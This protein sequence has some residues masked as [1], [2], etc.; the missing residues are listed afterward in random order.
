MLG[1]TGHW[2]LLIEHS[3][4]DSEGEKVTYKF[5]TFQ[6][7]PI[8]EANNFQGSLEGYMFSIEPKIRFMTTD[9]GDGGS[10]YFFIN[11]IDEKISKKRR[12]F[13]FGGTKH[14]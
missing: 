6:S 9:K 4:K 8:R 1:Y 11:N 13:G 5:G 10:Q 7:G 2:L 3:E 12:G 14:K